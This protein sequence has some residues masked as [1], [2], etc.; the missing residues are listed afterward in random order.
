MRRA[1]NRETL[2]PHLD[3]TSLKQSQNLLGVVDARI[4][5]VNS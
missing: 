2:L 1:T 5:N 3:E 4:L